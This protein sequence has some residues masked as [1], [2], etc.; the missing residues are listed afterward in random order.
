MDN[1][2]PA[3]LLLLLVI[4][5]NFFLLG[6]SRLGACIRTVAIQGGIL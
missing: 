5:F 6:S 2:N 4:L 3:N 1:Y